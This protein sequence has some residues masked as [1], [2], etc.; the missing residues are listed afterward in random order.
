[1]TA[2]ADLQLAHEVQSQENWVRENEAQLDAEFGVWFKGAD[3]DWPVVLAAL[4]RARSMLEWF[5]QSSPPPRLGQLLTGSIAESQSLQRLHGQAAQM[6]VML[7]E[8]LEKLDQFL[9]PSS[10]PFGATALTDVEMGN[11]Q[12]WLSSSVAAFAGFW[13]AR[14]AVLE[15]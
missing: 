8:V 10:L 14:D 15:Q 5:G 11:L 1:E 2:L 12:K 4:D 7:E 6:A 9:E 13:A 3:S